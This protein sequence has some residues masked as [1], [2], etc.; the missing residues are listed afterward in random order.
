VTRVNTS[1]CSIRRARPEDAAILAEAQ[2]TIA[3]VPG[4]LAS[5]PAEIH[6]EAIRASIVKVND[7][8][9]GL[10]LVAEQGGVIVGHALLNP[11]DLA[12]T[13]HV[14]DVTL[15]VHEGYQG[16]GVGK[17]LMT[18]LLAW[19]RSAPHVEKVELH[20]RST[21]DVAVGLYRALGFTEQGRKIRHIKLGPNEYVD[22]LYMA[23]WVGPPDGGG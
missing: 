15:A 8:G 18:E 12:V 14:V 6:D 21:N 16:K 20:V 13:A 17:R 4:R 11:R 23:M 19:A 7:G 3:R 5:Q 2:R 1:G 10:F 9:R 22:D